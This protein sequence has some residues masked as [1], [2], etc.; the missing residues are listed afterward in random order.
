MTAL[1]LES[2]TY[3]Y[4]ASVRALDGVDLILPGGTAV[5]LIGANGSGKTTLLRH[6]DGLLRPTAG[7]V[8]H[9]DHDIAGRSV[10]ELARAVALCFQRPDRQIFSRTVRDEVEFGP[11]HQGATDE[12]AFARAKEALAAVG[13]GDE[14]GTHPGDLGDSR[15]KLLSIAAVLSMRTPV[16]AID[17]PTTGL[18]QR[19]RGR[20]A[21]A[22]AELHAAGRTTIVASH[23]LRFVAETAERVVLLDRGRVR[24]DGPPGEVFAQA[25]WPIL[26]A[27]DLEP[28][29]AATVGAALGLGSTPTE[30]DVERAL[31][32][33]LDA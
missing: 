10:A 12:E 16:V 24:L 28:P 14:L 22:L 33:R 11:R 26:R 27:A 17:E 30:A 13:L 6:L 20:I 25:S 2:V 5:A 3:E 4:P 21:A 23:D 7:R 9:D 8:L 19:G 32:K 31:S 29:H 1:R 15:R 18:D